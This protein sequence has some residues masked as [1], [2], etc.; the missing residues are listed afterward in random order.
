[1]SF[2]SEVT[3]AEDKVR[4]VTELKNEKEEEEDKDKED[5]GKEVWSVNSL[6]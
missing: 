6:F 4:E 5:D 3:K 2:L 1:M